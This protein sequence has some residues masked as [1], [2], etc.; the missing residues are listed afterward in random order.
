MNS[1]RAAGIHGKHI[2]HVHD[3]CFLLNFKFGCCY[4]IEHSYLVIIIIPDHIPTKRPNFQMYSITLVMITQ[5]WA[6]SKTKMRRE[7][8]TKAAKGKE[9]MTLRNLH[10][11]IH[12][13]KR[14]EIFIGSTLFSCFVSFRFW[15]SMH[16]WDR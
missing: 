1:D 7:A 3:I 4:R 5:S 12:F 10:S 2:Y 11:D 16:L 15:V 14:T 9:H 6:E 13:Y 8:L